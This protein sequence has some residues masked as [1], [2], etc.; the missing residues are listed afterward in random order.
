[1]ASKF[2][3]E[4]RGAVL[5]LLADG[6]SLKDACRES[7]IR[8]KTVKGWLT[9]GRKEDNGDYAEFAAAVDGVARTRPT[10]RSRWMRP[11]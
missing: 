4:A 9:R 1:M 2:T 10:S 8:E 7:D 11:N 6:L 5:D 3:P